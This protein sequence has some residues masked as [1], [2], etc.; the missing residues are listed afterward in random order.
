MTYDEAIAAL[1]AAASQVG[2]ALDALESLNPSP[3]LRVLH[4]KAQL[5]AA[6]AEEFFN[7]PAGHF[8]GTDKPPPP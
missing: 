3:R 7:V 1:A 6:Q 5:L 2:Q 8:S 4:R